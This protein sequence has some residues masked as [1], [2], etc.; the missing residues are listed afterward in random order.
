MNNKLLIMGSNSFFSKAILNHICK[1]KKI[2]VKKFST[3][4]LFSRRVNKNPIISTL[5]KYFNIIILKED[6]FTIQSIPEAKYIIYC[7]L[8]E[9]FAKDFEA[10]KR[11]IKLIKNFKIKST[12]I[13]TSSG[14]VYG[15]NCSAYS[16]IKEN[17][18]NKNFLNYNSYKKKY[19]LNKLKSEQL[20]KKLKILGFKIA[21]LR[22]FSFVGKDLPGNKNY[23]I[24]DFVDSV[25][26]SR[27]IY[28][29]S[30]TPVIRSYMHQDD[31]A[32]WLLHILFNIKK[33]FSIYNFGSDNPLS[34]HNLAKYLAKKYK[35]KYKSNFT[36]RKP[37][38]NY[39]PNTDKIKK[40]FKLKLNFDS[41]NATIKTISDIEKNKIK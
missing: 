24:K 41:I 5:K 3:I 26:K 39:T 4:I 27:T 28:A 7:L 30:N 8:V 20:Y 36:Q 11:F 17:S 23:V 12:I 13:Y 6:I 22:C 33:N 37:I 31:L 19:S 10:S 21:I 16:K 29:K 34:I 15:P 38:D 1:N 2:Y 18:D 14:A 35:L 32:R 40:D 25:I 9:D